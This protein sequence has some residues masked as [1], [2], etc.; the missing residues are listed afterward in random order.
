MDDVSIATYVVTH[1]DR[2]ISF[3]DLTRVHGLDD[4]RFWSPEDCWFR[5]SWDDRVGQDRAGIDQRFYAG[6]TATAR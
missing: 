4:E 6:G 2:P 1:A 3:E 5:A